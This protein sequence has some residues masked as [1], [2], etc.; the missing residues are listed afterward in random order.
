[1]LTPVIVGEP[2]VDTAV[3]PITV[4][5][6]VTVVVAD[7]VP[8]VKTLL[9]SN[10]DEGSLPKFIVKEAEALAITVPDTPVDV[11][12]LELTTAVTVSPT[13]KLE[14]CPDVTATVK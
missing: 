14:P 11:L 6:D 1:L 5:V 2:L 10:T 12:S 8:P 4:G 3:Q 7:D 9:V 13:V